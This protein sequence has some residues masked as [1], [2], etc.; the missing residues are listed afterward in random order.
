QQAA[1]GTLLVSAATYA[2]VQTEVR[3]E[4]SGCLA[5]DGQPAPLPVYRVQGLGPRRAGVPQHARRARSPFVGPQRG[6][7]LLHDRWQAVRAGDGQVV[8]LVGPPGMGKSRLLMEFAHSL[9]PDQVTWYSGQCLAYGQTIPYLPARD[10]LRQCCGLVE[11]DN[12]ATQT[13]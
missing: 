10:F 1:P 5:L 9:P 3:G 11:G 4:A 2:L 7:A 6:L 8:S 12:A 13:A